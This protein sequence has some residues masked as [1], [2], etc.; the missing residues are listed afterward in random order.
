MERSVKLTQFNVA[1]AGF[2]SSS[3]EQQHQTMRNEQQPTYQG[4]SVQ[5]LDDPFRI[6]HSQSDR[7]NNSPGPFSSLNE[8]NIASLTSSDQEAPDEINISGILLPRLDEY[9]SYHS[10][11]TLLDDSLSSIPDIRFLQNE[12]LVENEPEVNEPI[13]EWDPDCLLA[14]LH[15]ILSNQQHSRPV[16]G[17]SWQN[18]NQTTSDHQ[19]RQAEEVLNGNTSAVEYQ[20]CYQ[21]HSDHLEHQRVYQ[22]KRY[23]NDPDY[24][25]RHKTYQ[26]KRYQNDPDSAKRRRERY[27]N[28]PA[29]AERERERQRE[30]LKDPAWRESKKIRQ[31]ELRKNPAYVEREKQRRNELHKDPA[32]AERRR[33]R[34]I[35][36]RKDPAYV[37]RQ[38]EYHREYRKKRRLRVLQRQFLGQKL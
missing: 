16:G 25:E 33:R 10:D 6:Y 32:Y 12:Y 2:Y 1:F 21:N 37:Q 31:R 26:R 29:F 19:T 4:I 27:K 30:R 7:H 8:Y 15:A 18:H 20:K 14:N 11:T 24:V 3:Q 35:E 28:D 5:A 9:S 34:L 36:R 13:P 17:A 38:R 22:R 23:R